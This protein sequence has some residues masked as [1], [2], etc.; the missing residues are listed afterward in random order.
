MSRL[1]SKKAEAMLVVIVMCGFSIFT[2]HSRSEA[3]KT[4]P[5][6]QTG[7]I[8]PPS[9]SA[10]SFVDSTCFEVK[11]ETNSAWPHGVFF[12][13][14]NNDGLT[15]MYVSIYKGSSGYDRFF[16]NNDDFQFTQLS[17][18]Y[19]IN[20]ID[21][22]THGACWA[23]LD[24][25]GDYD[26]INGGTIASSGGGGEHIQLYKNDGPSYFTEMIDS[27]INTTYK[28]TRGVIALDKDGD[29]DL[30]IYGVAGYQ[31]GPT[32]VPYATSHPDE[33]YQKDAGSWAYSSNSGGDLLTAQVA[34]GVTSSDYDNDGDMDLFAGN[35]HG[36]PYVL[37]NTDGNGTYSAI[38]DSSVTGFFVSSVS[39]NVST[40]VMAEGA[41]L[42]D[43]DNDGDFDLFCVETDG[44]KSHIFTNNTYNPHPTQPGTY[45]KESGQG[46][47]DLVDGYSGAFGDLDND[48]WLDLVISGYPAPFM[49]NGA[50]EVS[51]SPTVTI[52]N[53]DVS[54]PRGVALADLDN[55]GDLDIVMN[56][57]LSWTHVVKNELSNSNHYLKVKLVSPQGQA[58]A[59]GAKVYVSPDN[60]GGLY[61]KREGNL[62]QIGLRE[63]CGNIGY[64]GQ[65][66]PMLHFGLGTATTVDVTVEFV[67]GR[68]ATRRNVSADQT[69][70]INTTDVRVALKLFLE[71]PYD[72]GGDSMKTDL[73]DN[74]F[75]Q[76]TSPYADDRQ[77]EE[78]PTPD[79][80]DWVYIKL[81]DSSTM[82]DVDSV[83]ALLRNDGMVVADDG[84]TEYIYMNGTSGESYYIEVD[85]RNHLNVMSDTA[86]PMYDNSST[87]YNFTNSG[88]TYGTGGDKELETGVYGMI[89]GDVN[90]SGHISA[91]DRISVW[92]ANGF[93]YLVNDINQ[94]GHISAADRIMM[95]T[96]NGFSTVP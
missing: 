16:L 34:Q 74:T 9:L 10:L 29:G 24:N 38:D 81:R 65:N 70:T 59:L 78:I 64:L 8:S 49:N 83:S 63:A 55:D 5:A 79:I 52:P 14:I 13:D 42:G 77:V 48:G 46:K 92:E 45:F 26:L 95:E 32:E 4:N 94:S 57:K 47:E 15:D 76:T 44:A 27:D 2:G 85:H 58:G 37:K 67:C 62:S 28:K 75:L 12:A 60:E 68:R 93:G 18:T 39:G 21:N 36:K 61:A 72:A 17:Y 89:A 22:G 51:P 19:N 56:G 69:I 80:V 91:A 43:I 87:V 96:A 40:G 7:G 23:D 41:T 31:G 73:N 20:D 53:G 35:R 1:F 50:G 82:A 54:D 86:H 66:D 3:Q 90:D 84:V 71:G 30:D 25:D 88:Q 6:R 11:N 33:F